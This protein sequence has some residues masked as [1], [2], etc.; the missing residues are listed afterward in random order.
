MCSF[1][2][3]R[4]RV[5]KLSGAKGLQSASPLSLKQQQQ[6]QECLYKEQKIQMMTHVQNLK[7]GMCGLQVTAE[8]LLYT[9]VCVCFFL[10]FAE[11]FLWMVFSSVGPK[12]MY[13]EV[14][15]PL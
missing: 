10:V 2:R 13:R 8:S 4:E 1:H 7:V 15:G 11:A 9:Y 5:E 3:E 6:D 14:Y 12:A